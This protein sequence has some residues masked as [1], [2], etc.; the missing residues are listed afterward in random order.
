MVQGQPGE[1]F[2]EFFEQILARREPQRDI[3]RAAQI[4]PALP[5]ADVPIEEAIYRVRELLEQTVVWLTPS[6]D[7]WSKAVSM[8]W[9]Y[10]RDQATRSERTRASVATVLAEALLTRSP[11]SIAQFFASCDETSTFHA[12]TP[13]LHELRLDE[14]AA[15]AMLLSVDGSEKARGMLR[16]P[17]TTITA[18]ATANHG[19]AKQVVDGWVRERSGLPQLSTGVIAPVVE[20]VMLADELP[21]PQRLAW[22]ANLIKDLSRSRSDERTAFVAYLA[23]FAWPSQDH[24]VEARHEALLD[25]VRRSP[26]QFVFVALRAL[27]RDARAFPVRSFETLLTLYSIISNI[28]NEKDEWFRLLSD[29]L[30]VAWFVLLGEREKGERVAR[31]EEIFPLLINAWPQT[32][33]RQPDYIFSEMYDGPRH[34]ECEQWLAQWMDHHAYELLHS[35]LAFD[36]VFQT[37]VHKI[38]P[39][40]RAELLTKW[41]VSSNAYLRQYSAW[42]LNTSRLAALSSDSV[43]SLPLASA[44]AMVHEMLAIV[45][46]GERLLRHLFD[47]IEQREDLVP[48]VRSILL[49]DMALDFRESTRNAATRVESRKPR[50][51]EAVRSLAR[52][53][54]QAIDEIRERRAFAAAL[55][56]LVVT[57]PAR[58]EWL[59]LTNKVF[60]DAREQAQNRSPFFNLTRVPI[61]R[62]EGTMGHGVLAN[63]PTP[64][65]H[66][67]GYVELP[68][69]S[70]I[71]VVGYQVSRAEHRKQAAELLGVPQPP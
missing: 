68:A 59:D 34:E 47:F 11:S 16:I 29:T 15:A 62:G 19:V 18:W 42:Y 52:E 49:A 25:V 36:D 50:A 69:R 45:S 3:A 17:A 57:S 63:N 12:L 70:V 26:R 48:L 71:D 58:A 44:S 13:L 51:S 9:I 7:R 65:Q 33:P 28:G 32:T 56:E 23:C 8:A 41:I 22:R 21:E 6:V 37:L 46:D 61:A 5:G 35:G 27:L 66:F 30:Q 31:F 20:G 10:L 55:P 14:E 38:K 24:P 43:K 64:F 54:I 60:N 53:V 4:A 40:R 39:A 67:E 1:A 2:R